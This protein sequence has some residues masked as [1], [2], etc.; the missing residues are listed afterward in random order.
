MGKGTDANGFGGSLQIDMIKKPS[1][2]L[3][4]GKSKLDTYEHRSQLQKGIAKINEGQDIKE[5][6][7]R[8]ESRK[9]IV[10]LDRK[11][12]RF[13][14]PSDKDYN[15]SVDQIRSEWHAKQAEGLRK[16]AS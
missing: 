2:L 11:T 1:K 14:Y 5:G 8:D 4:I 13:I 7:E 12:V 6:S 3:Y 15:K 9:R 16:V 10:Q